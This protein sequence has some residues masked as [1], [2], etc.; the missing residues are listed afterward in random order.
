MR[1]PS[2]T[3][4]VQ[5]SAAFTL[6]HLRKIIPYLNRLGISTVYASPIF[7][8]RNAST[9]GYDVVDPLTINKE[10]G[11]LEEW[12][13]L[14]NEMK[15]L[16]MT[17]L[18][19]IVPNHMAFAPGNNWLQNVFEFGPESP[20]YR[21][22]DIDW[23]YPEPYF[24]GKVMA[25]FLGDDI[26]KIIGKGEVKLTAE[27][28]GFYVT[29]FEHRYAIS[30]RSYP[31]ILRPALEVLQKNNHDS[32]ADELYEQ[33]QQWQAEGENLE[34]QKNSVLSMLQN[35]RFRS[36]ISEALDVINSSPGRISEI[37]DHQYFRFVHWKTTQ[38]QINYRRFFT[39]NDLICLRMEDQQVFDQY[40]RFIASLCNEGLIDGLRIDH[41]DGLFDPADY[42]Q[43]LHKLVGEQRYII[44]EKILEWDEMLP[45]H[46][47]VHG[48]SGYGFLATVNQL[49]TSPDSENDFTDA[50]SGITSSLTGFHDLV[51]E[52]KKFIFEQRMGGELKN[53]YRMMDEMGLFPANN[54]SSPNRWKQALNALLSAF[55]VYRIYFREFPVVSHQKDI[56]EQVHQEAMKKM[57][58]LK[59]EFDHLL[60]L[61][62]GKLSQSEDAQYFVQRC[63]QFTGPLAAKG[64]EDTSFYIYNRLVSHNEVGDTPARFGISTDDFHQR[65]LDRQQSFPLSMNATATHDTKR[66]EDAR[67]RINVLSEI[68]DEWF[69][70]VDDWRH[71]NSDHKKKKNIP[72]GNEEYFLYQILLGAWPQNGEISKEFLQRT[73]DYIQKVLREAKVHSNWSDPNEPYENAVK[74]FLKGIL[75]NGNFKTSFDHFAERMAFYGAIYSLGQ[76]VIKTTAPGIPDVYQGTELWE[77]SYVD[78]DNRRPV[79]Y[80]LHLQLL[81]NLDHPSGSHADLLVSLMRD[82]RSGR[83]KMY[84]LHSCLKL[85]RSY[86]D[87]FEKGEYIPMQAQ[88]EHKDNVVCY[89]RSYE[90]EWLLVVVLRQVVSLCREGDFPLGEIIWKNTSIQLPGGAPGDW[91]NLFT[92][93]RLVVEGQ[94]MIR[95]ALGRFPVAVL[96]SFA[97]EI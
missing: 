89:L 56:L 24:R 8:A 47:P 29:Y 91:T 65:I 45:R 62:I 2:S 77:L 6:A 55:P 26:E 84:V 74:D 94:L 9:H 33:L 96:T 10:I 67:M 53:L 4:R 41:I 57:P 72:D 54:Q 82:F 20:Y 49:F 31:L 86:P 50:Y 87:I 69:D 37:L 1:Y 66:G 32:L 80:D 21:A 44:V 13:E 88:G 18:Q 15:R 76:C 85:R 68:P 48:T 11:T 58:S 40:H 70:R 43:K 7:Q 90:G 17:W 71:Y 30:I 3:Y 22:F 38:E 34:Q 61:F 5:L 97:D 28:E 64:V 25:P 42:L 19:D 79:D 23:E 78:P 46:W 95:D 92:T 81:K 75:S 27:S 93:E 16:K 39:I 36:S 59:E 73:Q 35:S 63:Q 51:Y 60:D 14:S 83:L 12:R 52:K